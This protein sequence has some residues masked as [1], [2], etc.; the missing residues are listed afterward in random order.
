MLHYKTLSAFKIYLRSISF[1]TGFCLAA[2]LLRADEAPQFE[3]HR[4]VDETQK[5]A[6]RDKGTGHLVAESTKGDFSVLVPFPFADMTITAKEK[7]GGMVLVNQIVAQSVG[8]LKFVVVQTSVPEKYSEEWVQRFLAVITEGAGAPPVIDRTSVGFYPAAAIFIKLGE[9]ERFIRIVHMGETFVLMGFDYPAAYA[10]LAR[11]SGMPFL[12]SLRIKTNGTYDKT[13]PVSLAIPEALAADTSVPPVERIWTSKD[14][15]QVVELI[16]AEKITPPSTSDSTSRD[17]FNR[18]ISRD[19]L[20]FA[21]DKTLPLETRGQEI[22]DIMGSVGVIQTMYVGRLLSTQQ[23]T[24]DFA[25]IAAFLIHACKTAWLT[26][27][28][29]MAAVPKDEKYA[30]R[31]EGLEKTKVGFSEILT[32]AL[33]IAL[34]DTNP[35]DCRKIILSAL[36]ENISETKVLLTDE[37]AANFRGLLESGIKKAQGKDVVALLSQIRAKMR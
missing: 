3:I 22:I 5:S 24:K 30:V 19:N 11:R 36:N 6:P 20:A 29:Y 32:G 33:V 28:E 25:L 10:S 17:L 7:D 37:G 23:M 35:V 31:M 2:L 12:S 13:Y 16:A 1:L 18:I 26:T 9:M 15:K 34:D 21:T 4:S 8:G 27:E 14:Y